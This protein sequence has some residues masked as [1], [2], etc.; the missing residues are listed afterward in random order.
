[1]PAR[2]IIGGGIG[3]GKSAVCRVLAERG[4]EVLEADR[5]GHDLLARDSTVADRVA[6]RWPEATAG[7][8]I[9]RGRLAGIVFAD[10]AQLRQLESL[11]HPAIRRRIRSWA[12]R[13]GEHPAAVE[14]PVLADLTGTGWTRV[15]VD[16]PASVRIGRLRGRGMP[17]ESI[18][19]RMA[20]Q[21]TRQEWLA[22]ADFVL[23]NSGALDVLATRV[24]SLLR[25]VRS[26]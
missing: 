18:S 11:T 1:M 7:G 19:A 9:D 21:P 22:A 12:S 2:L 20:A 6:A 4:F 16:A 26:G 13:L 23:D 3:S 10:P 5:I 25:R 17:E 24:D 15:T 14:I 8:L